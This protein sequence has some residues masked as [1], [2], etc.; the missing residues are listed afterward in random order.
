MPGSGRPGGGCSGWIALLLLHSARAAPYLSAPLCRRTPQQRR[1]AACG[2]T[3]A[4]GCPPAALHRGH[5]HPSPTKIPAQVR[6]QIQLKHGCFGVPQTW[7]GL[8]LLLLQT[9]HGRCK[10]LRQGPWRGAKHKSLSTWPQIRGLCC[11]PPS[12]SCSAPLPAARAP[13]ATA[14]AAAAAAWRKRSPMS[15]S[16]KQQAPAPGTLALTTSTARQDPRRRRANAQRALPLA[17]LSVPLLVPNLPPPRHCC[18]G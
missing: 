11:C 8:K 5:P 17:P 14:A 7:S 18:G 13:R 12:S 10:G 16:G 2:C 3:A 4:R 15:R 6:P 1:R 9:P